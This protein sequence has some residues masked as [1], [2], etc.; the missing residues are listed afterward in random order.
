MHN[1]TDF[2]A[3]KHGFLILLYP[4]NETAK[5]WIEEHVSEE[6]QWWGGGLVVELRYFEALLCG[7]LEAGLTFQRE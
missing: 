2:T 6:S 4:Q 7:I 1:L 3:A 5:E